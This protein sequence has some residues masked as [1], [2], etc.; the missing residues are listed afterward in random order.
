MQKIL[1]IV[2][3]FSGIH[4]GLFSQNNADYY[5]VST[6]PSE[7]TIDADVVL[8]LQETLV[9]LEKIDRMTISE[10]RIVTIMNED[11]LRQLDPYIY[12]DDS[13]SISDVSAYVYDQGGNRIEKFRKGDFNERSAVSGS[14]LYS[15]SKILF[16]DYTPVQYPFTFELNY[17]VKTPNTAAIPTTY[18]INSFYQSVQESRV[19]LHYPKEVFDPLY[20][21]SK[22]DEHEIM[23]MQDQGYLSFT[24]KNIPAYRSEELAPSIYDFSPRVE[25]TV[26]QFSFEGYQGQGTSWKE[27]G[28]WFQQELLRGRQELPEATIKEVQDLVAHTDDIYE[29]AR[30]IYEYVQSQTR[31]ISVQVGIGGFQPIAAIEVDEVKYGDCKGLTNY[32]MALLRA[33]GVEAY[34]TH[35]QAGKSRV[36]FHDDFA[37]LAQGNHVILAIPYQDELLWLDCTSQRLPFNFLGDFTDD[38][39]VHVIRPDGGEILKTP[40]YG[41]DDNRQITRGSY[42]IDTNGVMHAELVMTTTGLQYDDRYF[43]ADKDA[44]QLHKY[45]K[46]YWDDLNNLQLKSICFENDKS[47]I[48]FTETVSFSADNYVKPSGD[49]L[50]FSVNAFNRLDRVPSRYR[51]RKLPLWIETGFS[52]EDVVRIS[53]P[54]GYRVEAL[55]EPVRLEGKFGSYELDFEMVDDQQIDFKRKVFIKKGKYPKEDYGKYRAFRKKIA[56]Y[57]NLKLMLK[58]T[59]KT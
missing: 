23:V 30:L 59:T 34:Y 12:F 31:Y 22:T 37:S 32:T 45:Y 16:L 57:D 11:G 4:L 5:K 54:E 3:F 55:P 6:I 42:T 56:L 26:D 40:K 24:V 21:L 13:R 15:D 18:F 49:D 38:R 41:A 58:P 19:E 10:R 20:H 1:L 48:S 46:N 39:K 25:L 28:L 47:E 53:I 7:L 29:K 27:L 52:D 9:Q 8:R 44:E 43:L 35:V 17:E 51:S 14:T 50:F 36:D 2:I 33:V